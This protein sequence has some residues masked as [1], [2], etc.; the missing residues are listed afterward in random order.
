LH[1]VVDD[2][3]DVALDGVQIHE[4]CGANAKFQPAR[5]FRTRK[6]VPRL[7]TAGG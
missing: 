1:F 7:A 5:P 3:G 6:N 2:W 4:R